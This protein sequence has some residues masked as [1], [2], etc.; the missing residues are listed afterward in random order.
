MA[1]L[2]AVG[3]VCRVVCCTAC[4]LAASLGK[5]EGVLTLQLDVSLCDPR[6]A[7]LAWRR[8]IAGARPSTSTMPGLRP[9][10]TTWR[11]DALHGWTHRPLVWGCTVRI[12]TLQLRN[13]ARK[14]SIRVQSCCRHVTPLAG[15][16]AP[17]FQPAFASSASQPQVDETRSER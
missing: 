3:Q 15:G 5:L 10:R 17:T 9:T 11:A 16:Y 6:H 2:Q 12:R 8:C 14:W 13:S 4:L 1:M 7:S